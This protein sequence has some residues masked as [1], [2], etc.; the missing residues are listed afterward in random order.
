MNVGE[1]TKWGEKVLMRKMKPSDKGPIKTQLQETS[2]SQSRKK[3]NCKTHF[4]KN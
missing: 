2:S 3:S 1:E 4:C